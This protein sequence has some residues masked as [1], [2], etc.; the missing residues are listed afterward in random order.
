MEKINYSNYSWIILS[1]ICSVV[2]FSSTLQ[3]KIKY[4]WLYKCLSI[5]FLG[6]FC[7]YNINIKQIELIYFSIILAALGDFFLAYNAAKYFL[8]G[9]AAFL[10]AHLLSALFFMRHFDQLN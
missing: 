4:S 1:A 10:C 6:L 7:F 8:Q 3:I 9:L 2:Y 5:V